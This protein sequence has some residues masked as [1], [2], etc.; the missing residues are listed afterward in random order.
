M[1]ANT[2]V[3]NHRSVARSAASALMVWL[4]GSNPVG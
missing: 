2:E 3:I 4:S 1:P